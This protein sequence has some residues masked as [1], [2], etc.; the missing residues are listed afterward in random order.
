MALPMRMSNSLLTL[1]S[2]LIRKIVMM[3]VNNRANLDLTH[4]KSNLKS[5][6]SPKVRG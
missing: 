4:L 6:S 1:F 5:V 3:K 2:I